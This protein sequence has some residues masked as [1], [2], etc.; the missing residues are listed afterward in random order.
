M[1]LDSWL[2]VMWRPLRGM[3]P[4]LLS[5]FKAGHGERDQPS[6]YIGCETLPL[7]SRPFQFVQ[8]QSPAGSERSAW[9][10]RVGSGRTLGTPPF[11]EP[12]RHLAHAPDER[13][14]GER[15]RV[16]GAESGRRD[17]VGLPVRREQVEEEDD[18]VACVECDEE[19]D[20]LESVQERVE[21][22][23]RGEDGLGKGGRLLLACA[24]E[25]SAWAR[26]GREVDAY[27]AF[28]SLERRPCWSGRVLRV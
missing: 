10:E 16:R 4:W 8:L 3:R 23:E 12:V 7:R 5:A 28:A 24:Q 2:G 6:S 22:T 25:A 13:I 15:R 9:L 1:A 27:A 26:G 11:A 14:L 17:V 19:G 18:E 20:D 21:E